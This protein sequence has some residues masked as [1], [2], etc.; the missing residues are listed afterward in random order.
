[1]YNDNDYTP[2]P[3]TPTTLDDAIGTI[4]ESDLDLEYSVHL[5]MLLNDK[6]DLEIDND[7]LFVMTLI[8]QE[9]FASQ[10][11]EYDYL[12]E[13]KTKRFQSLFLLWHNDYYL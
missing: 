7:E 11:D 4:D 2:Y 12:R 8:I 6:H 5:L 10:L 1:M 9:Y 3:N 13:I